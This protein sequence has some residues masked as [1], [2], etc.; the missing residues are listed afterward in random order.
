MFFSIII[1]DASFLLF[2]AESLFNKLQIA[3]M[4][5]FSQWRQHFFGLGPK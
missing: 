5:P 1:V 4:Y 2:K 3:L